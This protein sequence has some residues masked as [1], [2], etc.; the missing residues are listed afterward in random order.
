MRFKNKDEN[1]EK[2]E[3]KILINLN[4]ILSF[5]KTIAKCYKWKT[6]PF[7]LPAIFIDK[8]IQYEKEIYYLNEERIKVKLL[9]TFNNSQ[10]YNNEFIIFLHGSARDHTQWLDKNGFGSQYIDVFKERIIPVVSVSFGMSYIIKDNLP[11]PFEAD[12]EKIFINKLLP[13]IKE[14]VGRNGRIHLI[15]HSIGAFSA[16]NLALKYP[17]IFRTVIAISPFLVKENPF[18]ENFEYFKEALKINPSWSYLVK[19][20]LI[21]AF[22]DQKD[23]Y[24]NNPFDLLEKIERNNAPL[25]I[26]TEAFRELEGFSENICAFIE[27]LKH[28]AIPCYYFKV[29]GHH[30]VSDIKDAYR[31]FFN[32]LK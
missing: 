6:I 9:F 27:K 15:G 31:L 12:L 30:H 28:K 1:L 10:N 18:N 20:N 5:F 4:R 32:S 25:I 7:G 8:R 26:I 29:R 13:Y 14:K 19:Y 16:F 24:Y 23:W 3:Y 2:I 21:Y 11:F 22:K 17:S